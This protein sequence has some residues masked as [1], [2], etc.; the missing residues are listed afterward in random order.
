M[1]HATGFLSQPHGA[2]RH[3]SR[4]AHES[5]Q[6]FRMRTNRFSF[7]N[8][9]SLFLLVC[10]FYSRIYRFVIDEGWKKIGSP[11][12]KLD[13][14]TGRSEKSDNLKWWQTSEISVI[15]LHFINQFFALIESRVENSSTKLL[16][17]LNLFAYPMPSCTRRSLPIGPIC[18]FCLPMPCLANLC[19][20]YHCRKNER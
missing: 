14:M 9:F 11:S 15:F 17:F 8:S 13:F 20:L 2:S 7:V 1:C 18:I 6:L 16:P 4:F 10:T 5:S 3:E 12:T 19:F